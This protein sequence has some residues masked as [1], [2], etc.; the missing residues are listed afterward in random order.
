MIEQ[1]R[2]RKRWL[3]CALPD[4]APCIERNGKLVHASIKK[5]DDFLTYDD[6]IVAQKRL[7]SGIGFVLCDGDNLACVDVD[8]KTANDNEKRKA[9]GI[10]RSFDTYVERSQ[11]GKGCHAWVTVPQSFKGMRKGFYEVYSRDR[12]IVCTG[13]VLIDKPIVPANEAFYEFISTLKADK[14]QALLTNS[15]EEIV[16][17][18]HQ[19]GGRYDDMFTRGSY[20]K[21]KYTSDSEADMALLRYL[22]SFTT[23]REQ[24]KRL[25]W[26]SGL[27]REKAHRVDYLDRCIDKLAEGAN[28]QIQID[29]A[30]REFARSVASEFVDP[31][32]YELNEND[33]PPGPLG[34]LTNYC[35]SLQHYPN[36]AI[37]ITAAISYAAGACGRAYTVSGTGLNMY[38]LFVGKTGIGKGGIEA[39]LDKLA[40]SIAHADHFIVSDIIASAPALHK[41]ILEKKFVIHRYDEIAHKLQARKDNDLNLQFMRELLMLYDKSGPDSILGG[42]KYSD[43]EKNKDG[44]SRVAY[45]LVG[46]G[47]P[48]AL[49]GAIDN[50]MKSDGTLSRF[51][52]VKTDADRP[53]INTEAANAKLDDGLKSL[54]GD[55]SHCAYTN[56]T[57]DDDPIQCVFDADAKELIDVFE[58]ECT[59]KINACEDDDDFTR[60]IWNRANLKV[61]RLAALCAAF[62]DV[63]AAKTYVTQRSKVDAVAHIKVTIDA[64]CVV[65]ARD[66]VKKTMLSLI[67][68]DQKGNIGDSDSEKDKAIMSIVKRF[69]KDKSLVHDGDKNTWK[70]DVLRQH[71]YVPLRYIVQLTKKRKCF[72][73]RYKTANQAIAEHL[74][75]MGDQGMCAEVPSARLE[76]IGFRGKC[77]QFFND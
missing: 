22:S 21:S 35:L 1:L 41:L 48:T 72:N 36:I 7:G 43:A 70:Y 42:I 69:F 3:L 16:A 49:Y 6:A 57:W 77:Y 27:D 54:L 20:D 12:F 31:K 5:T 45:S 61:M 60:A 46:E 38:M 33:I 56:F 34:A 68:E 76:E 29:A 75:A 28:R 44:G 11:S 65:W 37:A 2:E 62:K 63:N 58:K 25:F 10:V 23:D 17:T 50:A 13:D 51:I 26:K 4:K 32:A 74:K 40:C 9:I 15:D 53:C 47:T 71:G 14:K 64:E 66:F 8:L 67:A 73:G 24:I 59:E 55:I 52:V 30:S 19:N 18:I 39:A